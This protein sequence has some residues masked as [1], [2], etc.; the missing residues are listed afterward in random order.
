MRRVGDVP[1]RP[2]EET[3]SGLRWRI[4]LRPWPPEKSMQGVRRLSD[5]Y[6]RTREEQVRGLP[7]GV[8]SVWSARRVSVECMR[9]VCVCEAHEVSE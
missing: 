7:G 1:A 9:G 2:A 3:M 4:D 5:L 8:M 6:A